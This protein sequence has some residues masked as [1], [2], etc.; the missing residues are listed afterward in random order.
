MLLIS[1]SL[2]S[3]QRR[4]NKDAF[5]KLGKAGQK[6]YLERFPRST[7]R[8]L[9]KGKG[10]AP[11]AAPVKEKKAKLPK[12]EPAKLRRLS[13]DEY[14]ALG[15]KGKAAYDARF[16]KSGHKT[17]FR[18]GKKRNDKNVKLNGKETRKEAGS[19]RKDLA[20]KV[21][22]DRNTMHDEGAGT[23][24]K[25]SVMALSQIKPAQLHQGAANINNN[26]DEI[27]GLVDQQAKDRPHLFDRGLASVRDMMGGDMLDDDAIDGEFEDITDQS[28]DTDEDGQPLADENGKPINKKQA[29]QNRLDAPD[30]SLDDEEEEEEAKP[31]KKGKKGK[32][33]KKVE[34]E[35]EEERA[36]RKRKKKKK[37]QKKK[38]KK[39]K[40]DGQAVLN[41]VVKMALLGAGVGLLA[42]G[43][44]PLG[45]VIGR[46]LL[47]IWGDMQ[48]A[49]AGAQPEK[50]PEEENHDT[51]DEIITHTVNYMRNMSMQDLHDSSKHMFSALA[52]DHIDVYAECFNAVLPFTNERPTGRPGKNFFGSTNVGLNT[53]A[54][55][56]EK[57]LR[58][59]NALLDA[60]HMK[61]S[62][63]DCWLFTTKNPRQIVAIGMTHEG[64]YHVAFL[65][66]QL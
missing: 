29:K 10:A 8:F 52:A 19:R 31:D 38:D 26:R 2:A 28:Q 7:H 20:L 27:H 62:T 9:L 33:G 59:L 24:N 32:K 57:R 60:E 43:A 46:G 37:K 30:P 53:L 36:E 66:G 15:V 55:A 34:E 25:Q 13:R 61:S 23:I 49:K 44:G 39:K 58:T 16:P 64:L 48:T 63:D 6:R 17:R 11:A 5:L 51:V 22:K 40:R 14:S 65:Q 54:G 41:M 1:L 56:I 35:T 42:I 4:L 45:M 21:D 18:V 47:D 12:A 50:T 3:P